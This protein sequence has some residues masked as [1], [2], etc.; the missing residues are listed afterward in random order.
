MRTSG[1]RRRL[2]L[3]EFFVDV[4]YCVRKCVAFFRGLC[5][6]RS[7][8]FLRRTFLFGFVVEMEA[9]IAYHSFLALLSSRMF[10]GV[11]SEFVIHRS[12]EIIIFRKIVVLI[13]LVCRT[14]LIVLIA[15]EFETFEEILRDPL[16]RYDQPHVEIDPDQLSAHSVAVSDT[17]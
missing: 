12:C 1:T 4:C 13:L 16:C 9:A 7:Q 10:L 14:L 5:Q 8:P 2:K 17:G 6:L 11:F 3:G 15:F